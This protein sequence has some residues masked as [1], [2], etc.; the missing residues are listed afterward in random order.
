MAKKLP[1]AK[2]GW[3][4]QPEKSK[5]RP[6]KELDYYDCPFSTELK[7]ED[8]SKEFLI[9]L[10]GIWQDWNMTQ[11]FTWISE[12][13]KRFGTRAAD[14]LMPAVWENLAKSSMHMFVPLLGP[15]YKTVDDIKTME[16]GI[17]IGQLPPDGG[18][19]R[20]L[21]KGTVEWRSPKVCITTVTH[22]VLLEAFEATNQVESCLQLCHVAEP[23]GA[24]AYF[25]H[26]NIRVTGIKLPPRKSPNDPCCVW[27]YRMTDKPQPRGPGRVE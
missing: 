1:K 12:V 20:V 14:E 7:W 19:D 25:V 8:F 22:C 23:R 24:E 18:L 10:L 17:K 11:A 5:G 6:D 16:D 4:W 15:N 27:E 13:G 3:A 2:T 26:P 21:F 9:K